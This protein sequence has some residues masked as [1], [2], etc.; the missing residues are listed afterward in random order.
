MI[1]AWGA[2]I[3][4]AVVVLA[5]TWVWA[6]RTGELV[7]PLPICL[8]TLAFYVLP[9]A[10]YLL[11]FDRSPLTSGGLLPEERVALIGTTIATTL[12]GAVAFLWGHRSASAAGIGRLVRFDLPNPTL[13]RAAWV[14]LA[15]TVT[16][17]GALL[18][19]LQSLGSIRYALEHQSEVTT[20]LAGK[21]A[22]FQLALLPLIACTLL[23]VDDKRHVTRWWAW[24]LPAIT[25]IALFPFGLR[26]Y[27]L[28]AVGIPLALYHLTIRR[29]R[30]RWLFLGGVIGTFALFSLNYF[31]VLGP[32]RFAQAAGVFVRNPDRAL[33]FTFN[34]SGELKIF[35]AASIVIRDTPSELA[36]NYGATFAVVP[37]MIIPRRI[38][39]EKPITSGHAIVQRYLPQIKTGYPPLAVGEF[40]MAGG[41]FAVLAG[42][43]CLGWLGRCAWEWHRRHPGA[44]N[45][46]AYLAFCFFVLDFTR[47]GDPSRTV[48]LFIV[49]A[50]FITFA[51]CLSAPT[52][53]SSQLRH[54]RPKS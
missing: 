7:A 32:D 34:T 17:F 19:L 12:G 48:W 15:L 2:W 4:L 51:F 42:F 54:A 13:A 9:R 44:G 11:T 3:L 46:T 18:F 8:A 47:V 16:G 52:W 6:R 29:I 30:A 53:H 14:G 38:W 22:L 27:I 28:M 35:D 23:L 36:Y 5:A 24:T 45:S 49:A 33:H 1:L 21:Q 39:P 31:R 41:V 10:A 50:S 37:W 25:L 20:L 40:Y 43:W 26:A